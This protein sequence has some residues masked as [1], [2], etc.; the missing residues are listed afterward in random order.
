VWLASARERL[1]GRENLRV[2]L[3]PM[4][5]GRILSLAFEGQSGIYAQGEALRLAQSPVG[6]E[7][8][9]LTL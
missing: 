1:L 2:L 9:L 8:L 7:A 5:N 3:N 4:L 6:D